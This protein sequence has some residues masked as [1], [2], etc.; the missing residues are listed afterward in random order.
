MKRLLAIALLAGMSSAAMAASIP[1]NLVSVTLMGTRGPS[2]LIAGAGNNA[3]WQLDTGSGVAS[4]VSGTYSYFG[5]FGPLPGGLLFTHDMTGGTIGG[6]A[7]ASATTW[8]CIEGNKGS[9]SFFAHLCGNYSFGANFLNDS[10]Y[11]PT[12]TGGIVTIGGDDVVAGPPQSLSDYNGMV[13]SAVSGAAPGFQRYSLSNVVPMTSGYDFRFDV[14]VVP[15]PAAV[16]LFG[17]A[18]GLLGIARRRLAA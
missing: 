2:T 10:V 6:G 4:M 12:G 16:W 9:T 7:A 3:V 17:S 5:Q 8:S 11:T 13:A 18:L 1:A 15:V 14:A